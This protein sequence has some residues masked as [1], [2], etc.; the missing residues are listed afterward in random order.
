MKKYLWLI[1]SVGLFQACQQKPWYAEIEK[2]SPKELQSFDL[3]ED[4]D[5]AYRSDIIPV[6][7]PFNEHPELAFKA[8]LNTK[9]F[10]DCC[11]PDP[12]VNA[13]YFQ[14]L[15]NQPDRREIFLDLLNRANRPGRLYA[16][17]ALSEIDY[18]LFV[19]K[20]E[21]H[22][23]DTTEVTYFITDLV[24][25]ENFNH[26]LFSEWSRKNLASEPDLMSWLAENPLSARDT[27]GEFNYYHKSDVINGGLKNNLNTLK[28]Y[29]KLYRK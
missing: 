7:T 25:Y 2:F 8:L 14:A 23:S 27:L 19:E 18:D 5:V 1:L 17:I 9:V 12:E 21:P 11:G 22:L 6:K 10:S 15:M 13:L 29:S 28:D 3:A 24:E 4:D 20:L 16:L 26:I